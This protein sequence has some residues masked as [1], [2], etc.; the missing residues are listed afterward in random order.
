MLK[1]IKKALSRDPV[2]RKANLIGEE[3]IKGAF[4]S[5]PSQQSSKAS[6]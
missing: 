1:K 5:F 6:L 4:K 2:V 3:I